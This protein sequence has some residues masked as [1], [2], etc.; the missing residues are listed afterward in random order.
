MSNGTNDG[1][2]FFKSAISI[3]LIIAA[4]TF[5]YWYFK[6][7]D[8]PALKRDINVIAI[9]VET[10]KAVPALQK[11][12]ESFP[13]K[14]P[15]TGTNT[16]WAAYACQN[17]KILFPATPKTMVTACPYCGD[18]KVGSISIKGEE[19]NWPVKMPATLPQIPE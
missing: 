11:A 5:I 2:G 1:K 16:L 18:G 6:G 15:E 19:V 8:N 12:D 14:N 9:D 4:L 3:I 7:K 13:L 17:E 10:G